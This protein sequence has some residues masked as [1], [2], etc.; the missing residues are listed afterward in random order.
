[1]EYRQGSIGRVF[2]LKISHKDD[3]MESIYEVV[4]KE[5]ID[6]GYLFLLGAMR[7][8]SMVTGPKDLNLPPISIWEHIK[9]EPVEVHATGS[10]FRKEKDKEPLVHIHATLG[11][12]NKVSI[13]CLRENTETFIVVEVLI[14]EISGIDCIKTFDESLNANLLKFLK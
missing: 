5:K 7:S 12:K 4:R 6:S 10:I 11:N 3:V 14:L 2:V 13:G 9:E 8:G 1:M